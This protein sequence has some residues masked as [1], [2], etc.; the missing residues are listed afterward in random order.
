MQRLIHTRCAVLA[1]VLAGCVPAVPQGAAREPSRAVPNSYR[2][3]RPDANAANLAWEELFSD[4]HLVA[5]IDEALENNQELNVAVQETFI[6][7]AEVIG[8]R[9]DIL[10]SFSAGAS[11]GVERVAERT[12]Q[13]QS[14]EMAGLDENLQGYSFGL[15]ASWEVDIYNR[16]RNLAHAASYRYLATVQGRRFITTV[17]IA[18]IASTYY[19]LMALDGQ[20]DVVRTAIDLQRS[21]LRMVRL[22]FQAGRTTSLAVARF[23]A[24]LAEFESRQ[25]DIQQQIVE[26]ENHLNFLAGRFPQPVERSSET[27]MD[28][29]PRVLA[30]GMPSQLLLNR[31]DVRAAELQMAAAELDVSAARA[32]YFPA[33]SLEAGIGYSSFDIVQLLETPGSVFYGI[34]ASLTAPLLNRANITA[35]YFGADARQRQAVVEYERAILQAYIEV[36]NRLSL[37]DNLATSYTMRERRVT[38]LAESIDIATRLFN[39]A[40]ADYLE[41]LTARRDS[42]DAQ[43]ELIETKQRQLSAVVA[44]YQA[45]GGGWREPEAHDTSGGEAPEG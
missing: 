6:A 33:L 22:Q 34:F 10:P 31:P 27:F 25:Y 8:R 4:E 26:K 14:D 45:L 35:G 28:L 5:L 23:D 38:R 20:L 43:L 44:L 29:E 13:G 36:A 21:A 1:L 40:R 16:L 32:R 12:S 18:E 9:G 37:V 17:L 11:A 41:V 24:E 42:L 3:S 30:S 15:Y 2:G 7:R 19:E 39:A